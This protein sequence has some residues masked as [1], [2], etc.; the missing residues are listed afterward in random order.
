M[1]NF[2][3]RVIALSIRHRA[4]VIVAT[5]LT[6]IVGAW[7]F[8]TI[9]TD[10]FP[11]LTPN[12]V[13]V[14]T[15]AAGLSPVEVE[16][17]VTY[18]M[19]VAMLGL[20][21]TRGV[22]SISKVG[23]SVVTVAFDDDVDLYF[24]RAQV[25][26]RMQDAVAQL[27]P[28]AQPMLGPPATAMGE[29][30]E[31][32]VERDTSATPADTAALIDLTNIQEYTI[33]PLLRTVPG[34]ADVNTWGGMPQQYLVSADPS[35]LAGFGL[36]LRDMEAALSNNN[37]NFGAGYVEDRGERFTVRGL[38]RVTDT[39]DIASVVVATRGSTPV[40]VRDIGRVTLTTQPRFGA[41]TRD[42]KGEA[43]SAVV[44]M[45]KGSNGREV[46]Q[47]VTDRLDEIRPLLPKGV[48][49]RPFYNQ[50]EVVERT[51]RT[52]YRNLVEGALLVI[53]ILFLF[54][55]N[56]RAS[57]LTA[58]VIPLSLL[59]AFFAMRRFGLSANLM[60]LGALDF[61]LIVDASVVMIENCVRRLREA[62]DG[63]D[64]RAAIRV[65]ASEVGRPIV[66]GVGII[67]AVYI[68][69]FTL[70]G[71]EGRMFRPMAFTV[72]AAV[73]GSLALALT[74]VPAMASLVLKSETVAPDGG[75]DDAHDGGWFVR[76]RGAY[77]RWLGRALSSPR[78]TVGAA[79]ALFAGVVG[80]SASSGH[81]VHAKARRGIRAHRV[82]PYPEYRVGPRHDRLRR[83]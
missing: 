41:V 51:T 82:E 42:G 16:Q 5:L 27:P 64:V 59:I 36:S 57:L 61:G 10:A 48:R 79:I 1:G 35:K 21:R 67:V 83:H 22:R 26:Q 40:H 72:C 32:L 49:I 58:S 52:V 8:S 7:A 73:L 44:I 13:V 76:L 50:G 23:L 54:L 34:V 74:Y 9:A 25:Q 78:R 43:L 31:Y 29:V 75:S 46:V 47:R 45:L 62:D 33:K 81:R 80:R 77:R 71:I 63:V 20:P 66:F 60:S 70:E 15:S 14:M 2:I 68:P 55:R 6:A 53:V 37:A 39:A 3:D 4:V 11:D 24:A 56:V 17:Q 38:G 19:E 30:F 18:P 69:I 28:G 12:Q 65:A